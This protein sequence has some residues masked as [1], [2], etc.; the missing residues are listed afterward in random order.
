MEEPMIKLQ[1]NGQATILNYNVP[2]P[3]TYMG[4]NYI[5]LDFPKN[6]FTQM[7]KER[8]NNTVR[9][10]YDAG[11]LTTDL[12]KELVDSRLDKWGP[13]INPVVYERDDLVRPTN[14]GD[15]MSISNLKMKSLSYEAAPKIKLDN[16]N[17][18]AIM[19]NSL[20][21]GKE[22]ILYKSLSGEMK[23]GSYQEPNEAEPQMILIEKY[24]LTSYLG[25]Y[26]AGRT[27]KTF[28]LL[29]GE[30]TKIS[31]KTYKKT[32][33]TE[34]TASS[35]FDSFTST[36]A[37][38]FES[39][40]R[41][42]QTDTER[43][44]KTFSYHA[45]ASAK[46]SWGWGNAKVSGGVAGGSNSSRENFASNLSSAT[47]KHASEASA[48]RDVQIDTSYEVQTEE[49]SET[50]I[51]R[52]L[53]NINVSRTLNFTFRQMNQEF[54]SVLHLVDVRVGY[55]NGF[56]GN[57][58]EVSISQIDNLI[59]DVIVSKKRTEVKQSIVNELQNIYDYADNHHSFIQERVI[60]DKDGNEINK[61]WRIDKSKKSSVPSS[62][63]EVEGIILSL[64]K[65]VLRT[66]GIIVDSILGQGEA[67]DNYSKKL[68]EEEIRERK[69]LNDKQIHEIEKE[70]VAL[71]LTK[72]GEKEKVELYELAFKEKKICCCSNHENLKE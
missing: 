33:T 45:E 9:E 16:D 59:S 3:T 14:N 19:T 65:Y 11:T 1:Q 69:I 7:T 71:E 27:I 63:F 4:R 66:D 25:D 56:N 6:Y 36:S 52:V 28:S 21:N 24:R 48:K 42:E 2:E 61:Y 68:Q 72:Q 53:E 37:T 20:L 41:E 38:E 64:N 10:K 60:N 34:K 17:V 13:L 67:L 15:L 50:S 46:A 39:S 40:V 44:D 26:G 55:T 22:L 5:E 30:H 54:I 51:E 58:K 12:V 43:Y 29:P 49:G 62:S 70:Q 18:R 23:L 31:I 47:Q 32:S 57:F 8:P 35:I